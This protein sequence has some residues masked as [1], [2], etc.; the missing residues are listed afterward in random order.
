MV[1]GSGVVNRKN[2]LHKI[3]ITAGDV[4]Q[5]EGLYLMDREGFEI[6][7]ISDITVIRAN[8]WIYGTGKNHQKSGP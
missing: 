6:R 5:R 7:I 1:S 3:L 2:C 8:K 4:R